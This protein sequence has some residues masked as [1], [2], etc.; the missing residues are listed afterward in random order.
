MYNKF[1][2]LMIMNELTSYH[3]VR[4]VECESGSAKRRRLRAPPR[5]IDSVVFC[6][7]KAVLI[8]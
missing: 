7:E 3:N 2:R 8:H 5:A 4:I 6:K 1:S